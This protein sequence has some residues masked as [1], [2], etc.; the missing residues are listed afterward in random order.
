[1]VSDC[2][3]SGGMLDHEEI[4]ISGV[5]ERETTRRRGRTRGISVEDVMEDMKVIQGSQ[6]TKNRSL[7]VETMATMLKSQAKTNPKNVDK[8]IRF[9]I[10]HKTS[11]KR[12]IPGRPC[13]RS[14]KKMPA[15][16]LWQNE[17]EM[18]QKM[19]LRIFITQVL[20][21]NLLLI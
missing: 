21:P 2:C 11:L 13:L 16:Q 4:Q 6:A 14:T 19:S 18:S 8:H 5:T 20:E 10:F 3:H 15:M 12:C 9:C 17:R 1:M 7:D